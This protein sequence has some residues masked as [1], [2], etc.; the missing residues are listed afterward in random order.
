M[1]QIHIIY[2][3]IKIDRATCIFFISE[4]CP[5][6]WF[7]HNKPL[8]C[9]V[10][11]SEINKISNLVLGEEHQFSTR[12]YVLG[13][14]CM[15][16]RNLTRISGGSKLSTFTLYHLI[17]TRNFITPYWYCSTIPGDISSKYLNISQGNVTDFYQN[18]FVKKRQQN[19]VTEIS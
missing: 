7:L 13:L 3:T 15:K 4:H 2:K 16:F 19:V 18:Y 14:F 1:P 11:Y 8:S 6:K 12:S 17:P 5:W 9:L 10:E